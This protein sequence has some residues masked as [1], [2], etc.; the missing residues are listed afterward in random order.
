MR[1]RKLGVDDLLSA[2]EGEVHAWRTD[3]TAPG[4]QV[5]R[6][7]APVY[8]PATQA[9]QPSPADTGS[10]GASAAILGGA[11]A[12]P[13]RPSRPRADAYRPRAG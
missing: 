11:G 2:L 9:C 6:A 5:S 3:R 4:R 13:Q 8:E 12:A 7:T 1:G 10:G